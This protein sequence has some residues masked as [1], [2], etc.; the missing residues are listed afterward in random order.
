[1]N[2]TTGVEMGNDSILTPAPTVGG[3]TYSYYDSGRKKHF[4]VN[5]ADEPDLPLGD[6]SIQLIVIIVVVLALAWLTI[7]AG[8]V[9]P[10]SIGQ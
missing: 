4:T 10:F 5:L 2:S 3:E 8:G 7:D 1:M 6:G 9:V